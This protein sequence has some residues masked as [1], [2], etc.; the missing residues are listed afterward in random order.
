MGASIPQAPRPALEGNHGFAAALFEGLVASGVRHVHVCPGSRSTPLALAAASTPGIQARVHLDERSAGFFAL[1]LAR[2]SRRPVALVCTSGTAAANFLPAVVEA[3]HARVPLVLLT[4]D[5]PP[6]R[7]GWGAPQTIDQGKLYGD[8]VRWY[9]E[10]PCPEPDDARADFARALGA[11]AAATAAGAPAGPVHLNLP[12]RE[13]LAPDP[14]GTARAAHAATPVPRRLGGEREPCASLVAEFSELA[15]QARRPVL[16]CGPDDSDPA[17]PAAI[18]DLARTAG[19]PVIA[20]AASQVRCGPHVAGA[21]ILGTADALLRDEVFAASHAPDLVL[22]VGAPPTSK[23]CTRWLARQREARLV[24]LDPDAAWADPEQRAR[25]YVQCEPAPLLR[26]LSRACPGEK[27]DPDWIARWTDAERRA[28]RALEAAL[29]KEE[30]LAHPRLAAELGAVLPDGALLYASNSLPVHALDGF[31]P[32]SSRALRVLANRGVNGI[33][34]VLSSAFGAAA[35]RTGPTALLTGD[36]AFLHDVGA[37]AARGV[38]CT[39]VAVNNDG[40]G[41]FHFLPIA[42]RGE[43]VAFEE[44]FAAPH[45]HS[46]CDVARGFGV[47]SERVGTPEAFRAGLEASLDAGGVR[48]LEVCVDRDADVAFHRLLWDEVA[49]ALRSAGR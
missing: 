28:R 17:L 8:R 27:A 16:L 26:A 32:V 40:G 34:G 49:S 5:R 39:V 15:S 13:P 46:L 38:D 44:L 31:L 4:A 7:R 30:R 43:A 21:A 35:A 1:G 25:E 20:D 14:G 6:E 33:D 37:L 9:A 23:A 36:L 29:A 41:I 19:W 18:A 10:A 22:R 42:E 48:V 24:V 47:P 3:S 12:F 2:A 11:R 45:G